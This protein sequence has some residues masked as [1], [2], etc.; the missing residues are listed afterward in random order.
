MDSKF[1]LASHGY[2][3]VDRDGYLKS[4][5]SEQRRDEK[6]LIANSESVT[7]SWGRASHRRFP[8]LNGIGYWG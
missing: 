2:G 6:I 4:H 7:I 8:W 1:E 5:H 3:V